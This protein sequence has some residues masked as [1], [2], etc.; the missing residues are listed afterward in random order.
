MPTTI[1]VGSKTGFVH[2]LE[3]RAWLV[4]ELGAIDD[5]VRRLEALSAHEDVTLGPT[6]WARLN[7]LRRKREGLRRELERLVYVDET[8]WAEY[9][10]GVEAGIFDVRKTLL[11]LYDELEPAS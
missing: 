3:Y 9:R 6:A 4:D 2:R 7:D 11:D 8:E 10:D 1:E 5:Q